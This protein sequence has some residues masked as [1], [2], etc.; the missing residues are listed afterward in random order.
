MSDKKYV[1]YEEFG[2][3]GDGVTDDYAAICKAH[4]YANEA[5]LPVK[6]N[7]NATYYILNPI[8]DGA[9]RSAIIKTDVDWGGAKFI[10]DDSE[11]CLDNPERKWHGHVQNRGRENTCRGIGGRNNEKIDT[12]SP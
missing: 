8:I 1:T 10:I 11:I 5:G 9:M 3:V 7:D 6:A 2:A 12:G 4:D